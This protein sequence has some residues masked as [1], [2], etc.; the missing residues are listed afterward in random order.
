MLSSPHFL[1]WLNAT[2]AYN[3]Y[4]HKLGS[5]SGLSI[6]IHCIKGLYGFN[7]KRLYGF[8]RPPDVCFNLFCLGPECKKRCFL[9]L[10]IFLINFIFVCAWSSWLREL[11]SSCSSR[12]LLL[13]AVRRLPLQWPLSLQSTGSRHP[14]FR[15]CSTDSAVVACGLTCSL[16]GGIFSDQRSNLNPLPWQ[17]DSYPLHHQKSPSLWLLISLGIP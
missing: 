5:I 9:S 11:F 1:H 14:G 4:L 16:A 12:G 10:W 2:W 6:L 8:N 13:L 17:A 7:K 3:A 15:S